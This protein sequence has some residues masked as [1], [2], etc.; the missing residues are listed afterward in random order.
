MSNIVEVGKLVNF[1]GKEYSVIRLHRGIGTSEVKAV[2]R[3]EDGQTIEVLKRILESVVVPE[4]KVEKPV[5]VKKEEID[6]TLSFF[7]EE[8]NTSDVEEAPKSWNLSGKKNKRQ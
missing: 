4:K 1:E 3:G 2:L 7:E 8:K 5:V 6:E